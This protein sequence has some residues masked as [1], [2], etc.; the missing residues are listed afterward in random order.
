MLFSILPDKNE[1][2]C[3]KI[4]SFKCLAFVLKAQ[5]ITFGAKK[6]AGMP[7]KRQSGVQKRRAF[8]SLR[9]S[10]NSGSAK[11]P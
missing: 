3:E 1:D 7:H 6:Y 2:N 9:L 10:S 8:E 4:L 5:K 11:C